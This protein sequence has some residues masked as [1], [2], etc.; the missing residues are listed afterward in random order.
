MFAFH[1][2][3]DFGCLTVMSHDASRV[4]TR[5]RFD[6]IFS[7]L[8]YRIALPTWT[9]SSNVHRTRTA[10]W[11]NVNIK[12]YIGIAMFMFLPVTPDF[13]ILDTFRSVDL[14][15]DDKYRSRYVFGLSLLRSFG[16]LLHCNGSMLWMMCGLC[17]S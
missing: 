10:L 5:T 12:I 15:F 2:F 3:E 9:F 17:G 7:V 13:W 14:L 6:G 4:D 16:L 11:R 8:D 1:L